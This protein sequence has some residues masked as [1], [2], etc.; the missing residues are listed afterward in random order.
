MSIEVN[1]CSKC[2]GQVSWETISVGHLSFLYP[3][4]DSCV[5]LALDTEEPIDENRFLDIFQIKL[6]E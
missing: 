4:E 1:I 2:N 3:M 5:C 6:G